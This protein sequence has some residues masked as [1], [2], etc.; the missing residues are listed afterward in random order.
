MARYKHGHDHYLKNN[1]HDRVL[2]ARTNQVRIKN[3][4]CILILKQFK[5]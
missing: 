4:T 1:G 2:S 5:K 3:N